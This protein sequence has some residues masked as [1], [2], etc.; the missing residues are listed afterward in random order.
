MSLSVTPDPLTGGGT[1]TVCIEGGAGPTVTVLIDNGVLPSPAQ[2]NVEISVND[3]GDG[4]ATW[5]VPT[6]WNVAN[7]NAPGCTQ[8][9]RLI[10]PP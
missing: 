2:Q 4:C 7:F 8:V 5:N 3:S 9:S 1:A 6:D 10:E